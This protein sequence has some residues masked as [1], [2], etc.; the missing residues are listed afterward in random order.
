MDTVTQDTEEAPPVD[1]DEKHILLLDNHPVTT[2]TAELYLQRIA[3]AVRIV[4]YGSAEAVLRALPTRRWHRIFLEIGIAGGHGL[5]LAQHCCDLGYARRCAI[6]TG[7]DHLRLR[8]QAYAMGLLG[9]ISKSSSM[10]EFMAALAAVMA[11]QRTFPAAV[12][13]E[14]VPVRLTEKQLEVV[15]L[16]YRGLKRREIAAHLQLDPKVVDGRVIKVMQL[17]GAANR[18]EAVARALEF[19][20]VNIHARSVSVGTA[21]PQGGAVC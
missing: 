12:P 2:M 4:V 17:L 16:L 1:G 3:P 9:Y 7:V 11:G 6:F 18:R 20:C 19:G 13:G 5:S 15:N 10:L 8:V 14:P 21:A